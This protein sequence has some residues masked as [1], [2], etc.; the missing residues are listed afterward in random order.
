MKS[1]NKFQRQTVLK[2]T[3]GLLFFFDSDHAQWNENIY[4]LKD[5]LQFYGNK[6]LSPDNDV[7]PA[8]VPLV[9]CANKRDLPSITSM[10]TIKAVFKAAKMPSVPIFET[11]ATT[12]TNLKRAFVFACKETVLRCMKKSMDPEVSGVKVTSDKL[13]DKVKPGTVTVPG[14]TYRRI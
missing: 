6:I 1:W 9:V 4:C 2:G 12:G 13:T 11:V 5:L 3:D 8:D 10:E 7:T 14:I